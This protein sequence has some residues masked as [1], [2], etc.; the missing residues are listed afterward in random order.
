MA[1]T[2]VD[3]TLSEVRKDGEDTVSVAAGQTL[4]IETT[5]DGE[6][7]LSA[8]VPEGK[9]WSATIT[10]RILETDA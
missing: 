2:L 9:A 1:I 10:V 3:S 8:L 4:K 7:V 5:P 6:E